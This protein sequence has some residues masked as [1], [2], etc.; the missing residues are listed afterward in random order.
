MKIIN[1]DLPYR[2]VK[3]YWYNVQKF[4]EHYKILY[5]CQ[6]LLVIDQHLCI[7]DSTN[8]LLLQL[9]LIAAVCNLPN[10]VL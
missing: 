7:A 8:D 2:D 5:K 6:V 3:V 9:F 10:E 1:I 4:S